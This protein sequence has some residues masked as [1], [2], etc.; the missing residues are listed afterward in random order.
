M[1]IIQ[2]LLCGLVY[3]VGNGSILGGVGYY[4]VYRPLISGFLTGL[5]LG[6]P[7]TGTMVGATIN[8]MYIG[9]ISAGGA[10]PSDMCLAGV[11]GTALAIQTGI[12]AEAAL[13][14]AVPLGL[15][16]TILW[17]ARLTT[18]TVFGR[19][20]DKNIEKGEC[21][22]IFFWEFVLPQIWLGVMTVVPVFIACYFG[23]DAV[24][25][26]IDSLSGNVLTAL[27]VVG[28]MMPAVGIAVTLRF[29]FKGDARV[30]FFV[31]FLL[32]AFTSFS[33]IAT[34]LLSIC[35]AI[36]YTQLKGKEEG[37]VA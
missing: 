3:Y 13:A 10:L 36:I 24:Q 35:V 29:I 31:G 9:N 21:D 17:V 2:A 26:L 6:D 34:G 4:S 16:G 8:T 1:S 18:N 22:H 23:I 27:S 14:I 7:V 19:F 11:L 37:A 28:G 32:A 5:I 30:F 33:M 20:V 12:T 15:I 25:P